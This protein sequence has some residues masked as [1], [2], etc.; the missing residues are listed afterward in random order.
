MKKIRKRRLI[1]FMLVVIML[2]TTGCSSGFYA[3][4]LPELSVDDSSLSVSGNDYISVVPNDSETNTETINGSSEDDTE[5]LSE[6][7]YLTN[8]YDNIEDIK[9]IP[10]DI[11]GN[12]IEKE[13]DIQYHFNPED[14]ESINKWLSLYMPSGDPFE[15][16]S[17]SQD[18]WDNLT[19]IE[20][21]FADIVT[22]NP[23]I[24]PNI[25]DDQS[26]D[27]CIDIL[28]SG[29][30]ANYFFYGTSFDGL[31]LEDLELVK[32]LGYT[33]DDLCDVISALCWKSNTSSILTQYENN[34]K[35]ERVEGIVEIA[36]KSTLYKYSIQEAEY[37]FPVDQ[38]LFS[39][40]KVQSR[41]ITSRATANQMVVHPTLQ[42]TGY[43]GTRHGTIW[44]ITIGG[45]PALCMDYGKS[46]SKTFNYTGGT[47]IS[48]NI[49]GY[50]VMRANSS[51]KATTAAAQF[52]LWIYLGALNGNSGLNLPEAT[53]KVLVKTMVS[54]ATDSQIVQ[55]QNLTWSIYRNAKS[56][57]R[58]FKIYIWTT[59]VAN[60]QRLVTYEIPEDDDSVKP[61]KP[62]ISGG[63]TPDPPVERPDPPEQ[64]DQEYPMDG[65]IFGDY[66]CDTRLA[67][68]LNL[69]KKDIETSKNLQGVEFDIS[70]DFG[71]RYTTDSNGNISVTNEDFFSESA[72]WSVKG[73]SHEVKV[74]EDSHGHDIKE[75]KYYYTCQSCG[76]S[77]DYDSQG[78]M[79]EAG[80]QHCVNHARE[81]AESALNA[82]VSAYNFSWA[83]AERNPRTT[84]VNLTLVT[85][86]MG[87][88]TTGY[89][90]NPV[91]SKSNTE[92]GYSREEHRV[93]NVNLTNERVRA[94]ITIN[95]S[96]MDY[97]NCR[98]EGDNN[99]DFIPQGDASLAGAVYGLYANADIIRPDGKSGV[100]RTGLPTNIRMDYCTGSV[101]DPNAHKTYS[102]V[103]PFGIDA[104]H[105]TTP[106]P[107]P[108]QQVNYN[109]TD[110]TVYHKGDLVAVGMFD[111]SGEITWENL[112]LGE[113]YV[114]EIYP[115][116]GYNRDE[117]KYPVKIS[118][119]DQTRVDVGAHYTTVN[120]PNLSDW[121]A[122]GYT[123]GGY[124][125]NGYAYNSRTQGLPMSSATWNNYSNSRVNRTPD[126]QAPTV[127]EDVKRGEIQIQK[128]DKELDKSESLGGKDHGNDDLFGTHLDG[129]VY[130]IRNVSKMPV[131]VES[132]WRDTI[133]KD[134][135]NVD[136]NGFCA[137]NGLNVL[138]IRSHWNEEL[139]CYTAETGH[140]LPFGTYEVREVESGNGYKLDDTVYTV[141]VRDESVTH[142]NSYKVNGTNKVETMIYKD[143]VVRGDIKLVKILESTQQGLSVPFLITNET[144]GEEHVIITNSNGNYNS[145]T[146]FGCA[147]TYNWGTNGTD[148]NSANDWIL[149]EIENAEKIGSEYVVN[150][151]DPRVHNNGDAGLWF[152][153][154][155]DGSF[156][157]PNDN[158]GALPY[159]K[160][161]IKELK[162]SNNLTDTMI[163]R[164]FYIEDD[165]IENGYEVGIVDLGTYVDGIDV[166]FNI[167]SKLI[168]SRS[169]THSALA[170]DSVELIES[171]DLE[172]L[173]PGTTYT[174]EGWLVDTTNAENLIREIKKDDFGHD[175]PTVINKKETITAKTSGANVTFVYNFDAVGDLQKL[176]GK[177]VVAYVQVKDQN[178]EV[179]TVKELGQDLFDITETVKF[180]V[181]K[182]KALA[183]ATKTNVLSSSLTGTSQN[184]IDT[185]SYENLSPNGIQA[186]EKR[187]EDM[188]ERSNW[189]EYTIEGT[190]WDVTNREAPIKVA[191]A[192]KKFTPHSTKGTVDLT[193]SLMA[194]DGHT[195]VATELLKAPNGT[196]VAEHEDLEDYDQTVYVPEVQTTA[197]DKQTGT[198][199]GVVGDRTPVQKYVDT[200]HCKNLVVGKEYTVSGTLIN[201][202]TGELLKDGNKKITA[203]KTFIAEAVNEGDKIVDIDIDLEFEFDTSLLYDKTIVA[204]EDLHHDGIKVGSHADINDEDQSVHY[205]NVWTS[206]IDE[207][208]QDNVA[209]TTVT[210]L[211]DTVELRNL[212]VGQEYTI[213]GIL[214]DKDTGDYLGKDL[215]MEPITA[216][217]TFVADFVDGQKKMIFKVEDGSKLDGKTAVIFEN[218]LVNGI[219]VRHHEDIMD[220]EQT[221]FFPEI[222]TTAYVDSGLK[223]DHAH[224]ER[225]IKDIVHLTNLVVGKEYKVDG[226]LYDKS[227]GDVL[228][229][230]GE[231]VSATKTFIAD[232][233]N[234]DIELEF[235]I[236]DAS[237]LEGT[238]V[239]AFE[240]LYHNQV[241]VGT[242]HDINDFDQSIKYPKVETT[243]M[244][245][246]TLLDEGVADEDTSITDIVKYT[247]LEK[248]AEYT[249]SGTL[250]QKD[251]N[252]PVKLA[253]GYIIATTNFIAKD[254]EAEVISKNLEYVSTLEELNEKLQGIGKVSTDK[255]ETKTSEVVNGTVN[256][257]FT[258]F[259]A[260]ELLGKTVVAFEYLFRDGILVGSHTDIT[261]ENQDVKYPKM[262]TQTKD[263]TTGIQEAL[264]SESTTIEDVI[265][266]TNITEGN[267]YHIETKV[268][269]KETG[270]QLEVDGKKIGA[271]HKFTA[272]KDFEKR[273]ISVTFD[274]TGL[275]GKSYVLYQYLKNDGK[276][277]SIHDNLDDE[278]QSIYFPKA[279][280]SAKDGKTEFDEGLAEVG[281][282]LIDTLSYSNLTEGEIYKAVGTLMDKETGEPVKIGDEILTSEVLFKAGSDEV[283]TKLPTGDR[284]SPT[285]KGQRIDGT[286]E[287]KFE[288][289]ATEL[290]GKEVVVFEKVY[291]WDGKLVAT[292]ED[293]DD[294]DQ[295]ITYPEIKTTMTDANTGLHESQASKE[296]K[297]IDKVE[298][299]NL[300]VGKEYTMSGTLMD[301]ETGEPITVDG[302]PVTGSKT[303]TPEEPDGFVEIEYNF[304][305]SLL[306]GKDVVSF[307]DL[308]RDGK[309][310]G[311]HADLEDENQTISIVN[312]HT[313][314]RG[315]KTGTQEVLAGKTTIIDKISFVNLKVDQKYV[316]KGIVYNKDTKEP[317]KGLT[318]TLVFTP[319]T[320]NGYV[321]MK[322]NVDASYAENMSLVFTQVLSVRNEDGDVVLATHEDIDDKD[323]ALYI[324]KARTK[325]FDT[326]TGNN[327][328]LAKGESKVVD[329]IKYHNLE[330]GKKYVVKG[331]LY[332]KSTG[333]PITDKD[334]KPVTSAKVF[335]AEPTH[336]VSGGDILPVGGDSSVR[337]SGEVRVEFVYDS[338]KYAG[339]D[340]V[341]YEY[342]YDSEN[343]DDTPEDKTVAKHEDPNDEDQTVS[344]PK[345]GTTLATVNGGKEVFTESTVELVDK[346]EYKNLEVGKKYTMVGTLMNKATGKPIQGTE[347][348]LE[349]TP[350]QKDGYVNL[351]FKVSTLAMGGNSIVAFEKAFDYN[352]KLIA[353]HED[354]ND[355]NQTVTVKDKPKEKSKPKS[356]K[357]GTVA[358]NPL[359]NSKNLLVGEAVVL[360]DTVKYEN[361]DKNTEYKMIGRVVD[362]AS[363]QIVASGEKVFKTGDSN[364]GEMKMEFVINTTTL[365]GRDL[366]VY[367]YLHK[368]NKEVAR[369]EDIND[370]SQTVTVPTPFIPQTGD[371]LW[372]LVV[373]GVLAVGIG[374]IYSIK[375][376]RKK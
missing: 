7:E 265:S 217:S 332:S 323:E 277:V 297:Y 258:H 351:T 372:F 364:N 286:V 354:I 273:K 150:M 31:S 342:I 224:G 334:G 215:G 352:N 288:F 13:I 79:E 39:A 330:L 184:V 350:Q 46:C 232:R 242:H 324:P 237:V 182:T 192:K 118:W 238:T 251:T 358:Y 53:V 208:T 116:V 276:L 50:F 75:T 67:T 96:D 287:I 326:D 263:V 40:K 357:I 362:K 304:D 349:F 209:S 125:T 248:D 254:T 196:V 333:K 299:K 177:G 371:M 284:V 190:L 244:D 335:V 320:P 216:T 165:L 37:D 212:V 124:T 89:H 366:V 204:F 49:I 374:F 136:G 8:Y 327:E 243:A 97:L 102:G 222:K 356:P 171:I 343:P 121:T 47:T 199:A 144:T 337:Y 168:D 179:L 345:I 175:K 34:H 317:M 369:H 98:P 322:F 295:D 27:E 239:V 308:E 348:K 14:E 194:I 262:L 283:I 202:E 346:V 158:L 162:C 140:V 167:T 74:G 266:F 161:T 132:V 133:Q 16:L 57:S 127:I 302:K 78:S 210:Y 176:Y 43:S 229:V 24:D 25:Y 226:V 35:D 99:Q 135:I 141:E 198:H 245:M 329:I 261:D 4:E 300:Q 203:Y 12:N 113:Y 180:P 294:E 70:G 68:T 368:D 15:L 187:V 69:N 19:D 29:V 73:D 189:Q 63:G 197:T 95:K 361:L 309:K 292:H 101:D 11:S 281:T 319:V 6:E 355:K 255:G 373:F 48:G 119:I 234:M 274:S 1:A 264:I 18:W 138:Y 41:S 233:T 303:F 193:F 200:V 80:E 272:T 59:N 370:A 157:Q 313:H 104:I 82:K 365:V 188:D 318:K 88:Y 375:L 256:I 339:D 52:A 112:Y 307:E 247:N 344:Y 85:G 231:G 61:V 225:T 30:D 122:V 227:T 301:K 65:D 207:N 28:K 42:N 170:T 72:V 100:D 257:E 376:H 146:M 278:D 186:D 174:V 114:Q 275:E 223:E 353:E 33:I 5:I 267:E 311:T 103:N 17:L 228:L 110:G 123:T 328:G 131:Y 206:A 155:E 290:A 76:Q 56:N 325:A 314:A 86:G 106:L 152:G 92:T 45:K 21:I 219:I 214:M 252:E 315:D 84:S 134:N 107:V 230:N 108:I 336:D 191:T 289:D 77:G 62:P 10:D 269:D 58:T 130:E 172:G 105:T 163:Q 90:N 285:V 220:E 91:I 359:D 201:K 259:D 154:G 341:V 340:I 87:T 253:E 260:T 126:Y 81:I 139:G 23:Y 54:N 205:P 44:R 293:I 120:K 195:Y 111:M 185:V 347:T 64:G 316:V 83:I 55:L 32:S 321:N 360:A 166:D 145:S 66:S 271:T 213:S 279:R 156:A 338:T 236:S 3:D 250:Y 164:T 38:S 282:I 218:L 36:K 128:W 367:E 280:T 291:T 305:S 235:V 331:I 183:S 312:I 178:G 240:D 148:R 169:R 26:I 9:V 143:Q 142:I 270:E 22:T 20:K 241:N 60:A 109:Y 246:D 181:I 363:G 137:P 298:Y 147:H 160:Y 117:T 71:G 2:F 93:I 151:D 173:H 268:I 306:E 211:T 129:I 153:L 94:T 115:P 51:N 310:V 149:T 221:V 249:V 296:S 159:G